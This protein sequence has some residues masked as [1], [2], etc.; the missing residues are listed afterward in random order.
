MKKRNFHC[1]GNVKV[2]I[3][4]VLNVKK[5]DWENGHKE[6]CERMHKL[7]KYN[8]QGTKYSEIFELEDATKIYTKSLKA[9]KKLNDL[10]ICCC[11]VS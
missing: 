7:K 4:V 1:C 10:C 9:S 8:K 2:H 5:Y 3:I 6:N 11:S